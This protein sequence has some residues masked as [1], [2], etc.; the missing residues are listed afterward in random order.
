LNIRC[1]NEEAYAQ[2]MSACKLAS[3]NK[4]LSDPA[5][6]IEVKSILNLLQIQMKK[7]I[8]NFS[9]NT[10]DKTASI[11]SSS[12]INITDSSEVQATNL[13]PMRMQKK[14]KLKQVILDITIS[15]CT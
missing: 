5:F 9:L 3:K 15:F 10:N 11:S 14:Y 8:S 13:L 1:P 2:W 4:L 12:S 6:A 7:P